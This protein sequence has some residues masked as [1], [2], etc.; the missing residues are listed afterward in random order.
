MRGGSGGWR[1]KM[2]APLL[3]PALICMRKRTMSAM[4]TDDQPFLGNG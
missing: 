2:L 4:K 1:D 3:P